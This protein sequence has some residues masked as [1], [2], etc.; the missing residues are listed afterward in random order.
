MEIKRGRGEGILNRVFTELALLTLLDLL[1]G[2]SMRS[3]DQ[4]PRENFERGSRTGEANKSVCVWL[5]CPFSSSILVSGF[6]FSELFAIQF[7]NVGS[8]NLKIRRVI[9]H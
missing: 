2:Q 3:H 6:T 4:E 9:I 1:L 5:L 8:E 7:Y